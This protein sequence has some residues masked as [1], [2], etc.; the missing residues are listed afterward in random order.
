MKRIFLPIAA[1]A[2]L[3]FASC[4]GGSDTKT[5]QTTDNEPICF[6]Q[7]ADNSSAIVN[8]TAFKT[9]AKVGVSGTFNQV[10]IKSGEKSTKITDVLSNITFTIITGSVFSKNEE[11]DPKIINSFF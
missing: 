1:S 6:Y 2:I 4:G 7:Y 10:M 3:M 8:W 11:R 5:K 9:T